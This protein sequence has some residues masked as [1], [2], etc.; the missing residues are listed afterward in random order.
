[1]RQHD[2]QWPRA[3]MF[4]R[5]HPGARLLKTRGARRR[6]SA[7]FMRA[8][9]STAARARLLSTCAHH[10]RRRRR[11]A[12][13]QRALSKRATGEN[14]LLCV[15]VCRVRQQKPPSCRSNKKVCCHLFLSHQRRLTS[16][17]RLSNCESSEKMPFA[18]WAKNSA[19][20]SQK[21]F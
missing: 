8:G 11:I 21:L 5:L 17:R 14:L 2:S 16:T 12:P 6:S 4:A 9:V 10:C 18:L 1:M 3:R 20:K 13:Y 7:A 15:V 19:S